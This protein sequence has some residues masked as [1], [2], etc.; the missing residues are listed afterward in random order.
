MTGRK[1]ILPQAVD[2][3]LSDLPCDENEREAA[4]DLLVAVLQEQQ[5]LHDPI[6]FVEIVEEEIARHEAAIQ[7]LKGFLQ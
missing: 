3:I 7:V 4:K 5:A 1:T 6:H 2:A